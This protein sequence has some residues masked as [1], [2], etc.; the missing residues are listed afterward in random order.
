[1]QQFHVSQGFAEKLPSL[2]NN[3]RFDQASQLHWYGHLIPTFFGDFAVLMES[4]SRYCIVIQHPEPQLADFQHQFYRH[5]Q[6]NV[7]WLTQVSG[8]TWKRVMITLEH[9]NKTLSVDVGLDYTVSADLFDIACQLQ[10]LLDDL[11][12]ADLKMALDQELS[13]HLNFLPRV[14]AL[15][16]EVIPVE[17]FRDFWCQKLGISP[18]GIDTSFI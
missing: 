17:A 10:F 8:K 6:Q 5:L 16:E 12:Q 9:I 2:I 1:M 3:T 13:S 4:Q 7:Q 15:G 18:V 11:N 14:N